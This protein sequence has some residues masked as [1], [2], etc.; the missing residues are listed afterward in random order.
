MNKILSSII[1]I[2]VI[3]LVG[4][5]VG[6]FLGTREPKLTTGK[7]V[8]VH[9]PIP[10]KLMTTPPDVITKYQPLP[11][12]QT[13]IDTVR[14][15]AKFTPHF[16]VSD[17]TQAIHQSGSRIFWTYFNPETQRYNRNTYTFKPRPFSMGLNADVLLIPGMHETALGIRGVVRWK[18]IKLMGGP[19]IDLSGK[20]WFGFGVSYRLMGN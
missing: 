7:I 16:V 5:G 2:C 15:P 11:V 12:I 20:Y 8:Y 6:Y 9:D 4:L 18:D 13:K 17:P 14:L 3:F 1:T 10:D 19:Y